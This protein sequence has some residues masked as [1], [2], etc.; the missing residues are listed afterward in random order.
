MWHPLRWCGE[1]HGILFLIRKTHNHSHWDSST[2][3]LPPSF[4]ILFLVSLQL[5]KTAT[6]NTFPS[7]WRS[8]NRRPLSPLTIEKLG[9]S[10]SF[11]SGDTSAENT[12]V[13]SPDH[14]KIGRNY[15]HLEKGLMGFIWWTDLGLLN[16]QDPFL[17]IWCRVAFVSLDPLNLETISSFYHS[18]SFSF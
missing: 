9:P 13:L 11:F 6:E 2:L 14:R 5:Q 12:L 16:P 7:P 18:C 17:L 4:P 10:L 15:L 3:F 1:W 8:E